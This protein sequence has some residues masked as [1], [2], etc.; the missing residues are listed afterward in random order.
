MCVGVRVITYYSFRD[1][2]YH[3][4][5]TVEAEADEDDYRK[6]LFDDYDSDCYSI[7]GGDGISDNEN[8]EGILDTRWIEQ[9]ET[10]IMNDEYRL[11]LKTDITNVSFEFYYLDHNKSCVQ[12]VLS[13][14]YSLKNINQISQSE[15]FSIIRG[16]QHL[17]KKYYNFQ[18]LLLYSIDFQDNNG[19]DIIRALSQYIQEPT[20]SLKSNHNSSLCH[21]EKKSF[22]E[23]TN[24]LSFDV[25]YLQPII[26]MFHDFIGFSV[27]LYE[28]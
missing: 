17:D 23:Y 14:K 9:Y 16:Y 22:V 20:L 7:D 19:K 18:T 26:A 24:L 3:K 21:S 28:D 25:I 8:K 27:L 13:M 2:I 5:N 4:M 1:V 12:D 10:Q 11:F 6:L 15:L